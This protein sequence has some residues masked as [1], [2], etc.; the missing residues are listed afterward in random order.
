MKFL[1]LILLLPL[2]SCAF[3]HGNGPAP[4]PPT[5][6]YLKT[7]DGKELSVRAW[8]VQRQPE[9]VIIALHGMG[10]AARDFG[11][12]GR[13]LPAQSPATALYALNLRGLGYDSEASSRGDIEDTELWLRD[14]EE[15]HQVL[16]L[17]FPQAKMIWLGESM[18][19]IIA[20]HAAERGRK[21]PDQLIIASP[22]T[23]L[24]SVPLWQRAALTLSAGVIPRA[25]I[26]LETLTGGD[27]QATSGTSHFSQ[28][29]SNPYY[30]KRFTLRFI[31]SVARMA[32]QM[33]DKAR[34]TEVSAL[35]LQGGRDFLSPREEG[36]AFAGQFPRDTVLTVF[37]KSHHLLFYDVEKAEVIAEILRRLK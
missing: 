5:P 9:T 11:L 21:T 26:S 1:L 2:A 19:G 14:L 27:F 8:N 30:V 20:L 32:A 25:R 15:F 23:S 3:P 17:K 31:R 28:S 6:N 37:P 22:V 36:R 29:E 18:G 13:A 16:A 10:G 34:R 24:R 7:S 35:I 33:P 4:A 12:L